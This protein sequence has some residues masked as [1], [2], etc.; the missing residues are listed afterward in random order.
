MKNCQSK[1]LTFGSFINAIFDFSIT[2]PG[3][4]FFWLVCTLIGVEVY[5]KFENPNMVYFSP[6]MILPGYL[7]LFLLNLAGT[8]SDLFAASALGMFVKT[9]DPGN[10][11]H[12]VFM[13][14]FSLVLLIPAAYLISLGDLPGITQ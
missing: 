11:A 1:F 6:I 10:A 3:R 4:Y 8:F 13:F 2:A 14:L 12:S 5:N 9:P 7:I